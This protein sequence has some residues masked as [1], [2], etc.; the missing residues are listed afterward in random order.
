MPRMLASW[1]RLQTILGEF[2]EDSCMKFS[3]RSV[4]IRKLNKEWFKKEIVSLKS[5][6]IYLSLML[7]VIFSPF[8][9]AMRGVIYVVVD[10]RH[11]LTFLEEVSH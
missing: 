9:W 6:S 3:E 2:S 4:F 8:G 1:Y 7:R 10:F 11:E 5:T